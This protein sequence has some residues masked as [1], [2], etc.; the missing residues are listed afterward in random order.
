MQSRPTPKES[1]N[2]GWRELYIAA[3]F[4]SD[5]VKLAERIAT[6]QAAV[7]IRRRQLFSS[8]NDAQERKLLDNALFSLHALATSLAV[9]PILH[10]HAG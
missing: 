2:L 9:K 5:R 3:L 10:A 7:A 6:A 4:E 8:G 1:N